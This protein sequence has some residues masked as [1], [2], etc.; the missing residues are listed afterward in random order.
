[1]NRR[2]FLTLSLLSCGSLALGCSVTS[3][4]ASF[5]QQQDQTF[6]VN[7]WIRIHPDNTVTLVVDR[8]EMGQGVMTAL[9][10]LIAEELEVDIAQVS[11]VFAPVDEAYQNAQL[12][13]QITGQSSSIRAAWQPLREAGASARLLLCTAAAQQWRV[14]AQSCVA[15]AGFVRHTGSGNKLPYAALLQV[16]STLPLPQHIRLKPANEF[17][18]IGQSIPRLDAAAKV[19]GSAEFG[20]DIVRPNMQIAVVVRCPVRGGTV[21]S[22]EY[23]GTLESLHVRQVVEIPQGIAVV[24]DDYWHARQAANQVQVVWD[25]GALATVNSEDIAQQQRALAEDSGDAVWSQGDVE[26]GMAAAPIQLSAEYAL[27]YLAHTTMEP[28]NCTALITEDHC[29]LWAPTQ[30]PEVAQHIAA[31][32]TGFDKANIQVH[33]PF[34][35]G[36]FG[37][38]T[39]QDYV[40]EAV[41]IA[42]LQPGVPIKLVWSR[43]D[44]I[45]NDHYRP[46]TTHRLQAG[47]TVQGDVLAWYHHIV[48]PSILAQLAPALL[49]PKLDWMPH[50]M[51]AFS[52]SIVSYALKH[53]TEDVTSVEGAAPLRYDIANVSVEYTHHDVGL[54]VGFWR[55]VGHSYNAFVVESFVDEMAHAMGQDP[56]VLRRK[57]LRPYPRALAV[58]DQ[59]A[60]LAK[61]HE[62]PAP[63]HF[64]GIA[65]HAA[66]DSY[67]AQVA[68]VSV[69]GKQIKVHRVS[70]VIDCGIAINPDIVKA[71]MEGAIVFGLSAALKGHIT[72]TNGRV[73]QSNFHDYPVLRMS[74]MPDIE[75]FIVASEAAPAGVGEPG[76][77][78]I[79]PALANAVFAATGKRLR[80]LP[81]DLSAA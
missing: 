42:L 19:D 25:E 28:M 38:R 72:L 33:T 4:H 17:H 21:T 49:A 10:M 47:V 24:A 44:D 61:W 36:G 51:N 52:G 45:R 69:E 43:E 39:I 3:P 8:V 27:P 73:S 78:P 23:P 55:S 2:H 53:W 63:G 76:T 60:A 41:E 66:F 80:Q 71:Q 32:I 18:T 57:L 81:L 20:L 50:F 29:E 40:S 75:V 22:F 26:E 31:Q 5:H 65:Q 37:R 46:A 12:G 14:E 59:V 64:L 54:P 35:G 34:L 56:Y 16:A 6:A 30:A 58:L 70:C 9:P 13:G 48:G 11:V 62:T 7:A 77:P 74:E 15:Q 1:M 79:A 67:V 68:E